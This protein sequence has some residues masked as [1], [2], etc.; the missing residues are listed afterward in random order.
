MNYTTKESI[1]CKA[2][3]WKGDNLEEIERLVGKDKV[4]RWESISDTGIFINTYPLE[5]HWDLLRLKSWLVI[6]QDYGIDDPIIY[7]DQEFKAKFKPV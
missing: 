7:T 6:Y 3:Q 4:S 2:V 5:G 1:S